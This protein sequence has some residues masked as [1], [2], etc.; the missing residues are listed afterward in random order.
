M[1]EEIE[2]RHGHLVVTWRGDVNENNESIKIIIHLT[3]TRPAC[4][5]DSLASPSQGLGLAYP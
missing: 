1:G 3:C 5:L 4:K 2:R